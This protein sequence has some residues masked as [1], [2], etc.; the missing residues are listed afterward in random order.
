MDEPPISMKKFARFLLTLESNCYLCPHKTRNAFDIAVLISLLLTEYTSGFRVELRK[1]T[2]A[3]QNQTW[4]ISSLAQGFPVD[5]STNE[6]T[7]DGDHS[8]TNNKT[9][10]R[11]VYA[12]FLFLAIAAARVG[13][14]WL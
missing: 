2:N 11:T 14:V 3:A 8:R 7:S 6:S 5:N 13:L 12:Y 1:E 4:T 9:T 10:I